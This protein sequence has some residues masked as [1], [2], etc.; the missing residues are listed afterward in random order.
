MKTITIPAAEAAQ[1]LID[2]GLLGEI[3]RAILHPRGLALGIQVDDNDRAVGFAGL[4]DYRDDAEGIYFDDETCQELTAKLAVYD[5]AHPLKN[6][7][8]GIANMPV[9]KK[10]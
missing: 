2:S 7:A 8:A 4:L 5:A 1:L 10:E 3:N 6:I 9:S